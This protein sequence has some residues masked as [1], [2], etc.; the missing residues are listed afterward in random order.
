MNV[1]PASFP[2]LRP[3]EPNILLETQA[4]FE[5]PRVEPSSIMVSVR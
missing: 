4:V 1:K 5:C 2:P 3:G